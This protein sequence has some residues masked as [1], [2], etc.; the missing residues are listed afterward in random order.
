M[1]YE[2]S[3]IYM[4]TVMLVS[5]GDTA[6]HQARPGLH[7]KFRGVPPFP[8]VFILFKWLKAIE[9]RMP[10]CGALFFNICKLKKRDFFFSFKCEN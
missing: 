10:S 3:H 4:T 9:M 2:Q 7:T 6:A 8:V 1:G 5:S